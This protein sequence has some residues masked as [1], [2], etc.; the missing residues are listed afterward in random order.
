MPVLQRFDGVGVDVAFEL[1]GLVALLPDHPLQR[2]ERRGLAV[3]GN[4]AQQNLDHPLDVGI[5]R[6]A[7]A[8]HAGQLFSDVIA[9]GVLTDK[10]RQVFRGVGKQHVEHKTHRAGGAFDVGENRFDRHRFS[11]QD[12]GS[13]QRCLRR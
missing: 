12:A 2:L 6:V 13:G 1:P 3:F 10:V 4:P 7:V 9:P 8:A 11:P 5:R